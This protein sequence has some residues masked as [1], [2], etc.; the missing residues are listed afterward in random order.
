MRMLNGRYRL[1]HRIAVGGASEVW[2]GHDEMLDRAV[3]VKVMTLGA[4]GG[5]DALSE[6]RSEARAAAALT[7]PNIAGVYDFGACPTAAGLA[8]RFIVMELA[9]GETLAVHLRGG[10][11]DWQIAVRVCAEVCAAL[12]AAH[13]HG[14]VHRDIKPANVILTPYGAKVL[15]FGIS[16]M[17]GNQD[18]LPDGNLVGTPAFIA[19]ERFRGIPAAPS[20]DMYAVGVLLY[21]CL[22]GK[23]PWPVPADPTR[24]AAPAEPPPL[25]DLPGLPVEVAD[26]CASCLDPDPERRPTSFLAALLLAEAVDATIHLP[27]VATAGPDEPPAVS[28]WTRAAAEA[29]TNHAVAPVENPEPDTH[30]GRHRA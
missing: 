30:V 16:V 29:V 26:L 24:P 1:E 19:P 7:H 8:I 14:V 20:T 6:V 11:L 10:P 21:L 2:R 5:T 18:L 12:A 22:S 28:P 3:A 15:D 4:D 9:E 17:S 25:P 27:P 13:L 23:L